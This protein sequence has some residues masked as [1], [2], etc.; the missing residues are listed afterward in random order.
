MKDIDKRIIKDCID[1]GFDISGI[2]DTT[3]KDKSDKGDIYHKSISY[4][5]DTI[6]IGIGIILKLREKS[7]QVSRVF[8]YITRHLKYN[9]T[10]IILS[11]ST[12]AREYDDDRSNI[13]KA[14]KELENMD[15]IRKVS[16]FVPNNTLPK[17]T[18]EVN[19]NYIC[20][21]DCKFIKQLIINQRKHGNIES[22]NQETSS[23]S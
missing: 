21:G 11:A 9:S 17:N 3:I 5:P 22:K 4:M 23:G 18:Y 10:N 2:K 20:N 13:H 12:I 14:I 16:K 8:D 15:V 6:K 1:V 7:I 19:F